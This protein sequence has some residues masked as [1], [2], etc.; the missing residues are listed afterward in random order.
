MRASVM[1][2]EGTLWMEAEVPVTA[3]PFA[4]KERFLD[5]ESR[6]R[7]GCNAA[8]ARTRVQLRGATR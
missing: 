3:S 6:R 4:M 2:V 5:S 7:A 8:N 1:M